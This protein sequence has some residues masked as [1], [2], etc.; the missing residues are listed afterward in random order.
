[1]GTQSYLTPVLIHGFSR[2]HDHNDSL[3]KISGVG[4]S[5]FMLHCDKN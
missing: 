5:V 2:K 3:R 4:Q 1:M